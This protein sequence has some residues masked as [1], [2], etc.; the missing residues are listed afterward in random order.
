MT[1]RDFLEEVVRLNVVDFRQHFGSLRH[2]FNA[3]AGV[4]ALAAHIYE[5]LRANL[6]AEVDG[7]LRDDDYRDSLASKSTDYRLVRDIAAAQKHVRLEGKK[8]RLV[9]SAGQIAAASLGWGE[10]HW[11]AGRWGGVSQ[12]I[13]NTE[14]GDPRYVELAIDAALEFLE[15]EITRLRI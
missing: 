1:P 5:W 13:A 2:A 4:D 12:V 9:R 14:E 6:P 11:G 8:L 15:R 10:G 7:K 3:A